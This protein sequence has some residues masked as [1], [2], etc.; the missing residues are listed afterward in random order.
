MKTLRMFA[1]F[2]LVAMSLFAVSAEAQ[3]ISVLFG[4]EMADSKQV[5][6]FDS[7]DINI[8][9]SNIDD[10]IGA[11]EYTLNLPA[12]VAI[13]GSNYWNGTNLVL[14]GPDGTAIA[15]GECVVMVNSPGIDQEITVANFQAIAVNTFSSTA[16]TLT[17]YTGTPSNPGTA[18]RY[19]NCQDQLVNLTPVAGTLEGVTVATEATSFSKVKSL[20]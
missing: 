11:V 12:N 14:D 6:M 13:T 3:E 10:T 16:V 2:A 5:K 4:N 8:V 7:F 19:A 9:V 18:P 1:A 17:E 20:F 15:L